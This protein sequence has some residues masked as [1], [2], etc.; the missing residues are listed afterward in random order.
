MKVLL[1]K[2]YESYQ[3]TL[4]IPLKDETKIYVYTQS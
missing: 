4:D 1:L 2:T 3:H